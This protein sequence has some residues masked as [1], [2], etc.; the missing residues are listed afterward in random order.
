MSTQIFD[1]KTLIAQTPTGQTLFTTQVPVNQ[2]ASDG[3]SYEL[4]MKFQSAKAGQITAIR[5]WKAASESGTHIGKIWSTTGNTLATVTFTNE[6]ASGWQQQALSTPL[7]IQANII[8]IV[9]VNIISY[10]PIT[11]D[12]LTSSVVNGD[13]SSVA[14]GNNAVFGS[15]NTLPTNSF[16]N[17]NYYRD[18]V[19][20]AASS[21]IQVSGDNQSAASGTALPN[22]LVVQVNNS[23]GNPQSGVT[24]NFAI[25]S[26]S[27]S[28]S[29]SSAVTNAS[30]QASTVLTLG[31]ATN[32]SAVT[33]TATASGIGSV[34]FSAKVRPANP[35]AIYL[36]NQR[37]GTTNWR[38]SNPV[39]ESAPEIVGYASAA[40]VNKGG[41]LPIKVSLAQ[42]GS[43]QVD[44]YRLGYYAGAGGRLILSASNLNGITQPA[45]TITDTNTNLVECKWSTSYTLAVSASWV[46]GLYIAKLTEQKS[47]KQTQ[48]WFVVRDDSSTS[49]VLFQSSFSTFQAYNNAGQYSLYSWNS[50]G[51][52]SALKVSYDRPFSQT[53]TRTIESNNILRWEYNMAR[54]L[55]SQ[56]YNVSYVTNVDAHANS[57]LLPQHK[58]FLSVGHDEYW[59]LEERNNVEQSRNAGVNLAFF[60]SNTCYWRVRYENSSTGVT[61]R[62]MACYKE[63]WAKDPVAPTNKF[64][65]PQNNKPENGLLGV[66][67]TGDTNDYYGGYDFVVSNS[68]DP[69]FANTNLSNG[70]KLTQLVGFEWDAV[71]NNGFSP[72]GLVTLSQSSVNPVPANSIDPD[73]PPGTNYQ[74]ANA[75]RYTT[76]GGAKV[77]AVGSNQW[78]WGLDSDGVSTPREDVRAKQITVNILADMGA[79]PQT[80]DANIVVP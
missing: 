42:S 69:Y 56:S 24:V 25:A 29:P 27:G 4:G 75:V 10:F 7:N 34:T 38:I 44:I 55:E 57:Q 18:I 33:V 39:T 66:M 23:G 16:R 2:N 52:Q 35:N 1:N 78:M 41:S 28:V 32:N 80:P 72:S 68:T 51:G 21:I 46:S 22:P 45:C 70:D 65:S 13:L 37:P 73:V 76:P 53:S 47:S 77:F 49:E 43:F 26:G 74:V 31:S 64:R 3:V 9:S 79:K 15:P 40:S 59:S 5:Y 48:V 63:N 61:N 67:Y 19:F 36:E 30:G 58:V 50:L 60:S 6:T 11:L 12:E 17:S 71:I 8:Y 54:W 14:D 20:L 62:V